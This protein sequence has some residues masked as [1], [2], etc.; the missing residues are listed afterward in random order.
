MAS[1]PVDRSRALWHRQVV[2]T[3]L[4]VP[5]FGGVAGLTRLALSEWGRAPDNRAEFLALAVIVG[6][7]IIT[8]LGAVCVHALRIVRLTFAPKKPVSEI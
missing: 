2:L 1:A 5:A 3:A 6:V 4:A 8:L 7:A